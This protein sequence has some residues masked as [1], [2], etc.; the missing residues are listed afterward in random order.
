[1]LTFD[2]FRTDW[3]YPTNTYGLRMAYYSRCVVLT[4]DFTIAAP[5][6]RVWTRIGRIYDYFIL[7]RPF[8]LIDYTP[9]IPTVFAW[10]ITPIVLYLPWTLPSPRLDREYGLAL[11][12]FF[13]Y[14]ETLCNVLLLRV[15]LFSAH[16]TITVPG[17]YALILAVFIRTWC[18]FLSIYL[19]VG[20]VEP[21][22]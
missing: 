8:V 11:V 13:I 9:R 14:F 2:N 19:T 1:M 12:A 4:M 7:F 5:R 20:I 3:L 18:L 22:G 10:L 17:E 21:R 15:V 6:S 16:K